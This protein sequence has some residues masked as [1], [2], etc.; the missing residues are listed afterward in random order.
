MV[1]F[2]IVVVVG[3]VI[4]W[5]VYRYGDLVISDDY[6]CK[7][8]VVMQMFV[9][10]ECVSVF[11]LYVCM[12]LIVDDVVSVRLDV[13]QVGFQLLVVICVMLL[14]LI[15]VGLDQIEVLYLNSGVYVGCLYLLVF[16]YWLLLLEDEVQGW[17][18]FGKVILLV[19]EVKIDVIVF[20]CVLMF[21]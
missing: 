7:G 4:V 20:Q 9:S 13:D 15:C 14:Y 1:G 8:L 21:V 17:C 2:L 6:Y 12:C 10:S 3:I 19:I 11:G 16:G 5:I 18:M